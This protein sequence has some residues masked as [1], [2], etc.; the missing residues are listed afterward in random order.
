M[1]SDGP[2]HRFDSPNVSGSNRRRHA[3]ASVASKVNL[4]IETRDGLVTLSGYV[5]DISVSGCA[6]HLQNRVEPHLAGRVQLALG[7]DEV[8][9]PIVTRWVRPDAKGWSVGAEFD[10]PTREK[11][12]LVRRFVAQ[13]L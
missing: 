8:W 9:L 5:I 7:R 3:R 1:R 13:R 2:A 11:H 10:R 4:L 12:D 6:I